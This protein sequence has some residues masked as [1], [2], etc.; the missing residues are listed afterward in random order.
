M[1]PIKSL[2]RS[3]SIV[4]EPLKICVSVPVEQIFVWLKEHGKYNHEVSAAVRIYISR[5][6]ICFQT[7]MFQSKLTE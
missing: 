1:Q 7:I 3:K 6:Q 4:Y 5:S 2:A